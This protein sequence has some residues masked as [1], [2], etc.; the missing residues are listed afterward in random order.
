MVVQPKPKPEGIQWWATLQP[1]HPTAQ[2]DLQRLKIIN[3]LDINMSVLLARFQVDH[4]QSAE[5]PTDIWTFGQFTEFVRIGLT[6]DLSALRNT[7]NL[8]LHEPA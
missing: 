2:F 5:D 6:D 4:C 1:I 3:L 8:K 7:C